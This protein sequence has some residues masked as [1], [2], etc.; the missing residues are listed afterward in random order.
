MLCSSQFAAEWRCEVIETPYA[1]KQA[2]P[3]KVAIS[4]ASIGRTKLYELLND[5]T[6]KSVKI[7]RKRLILR[8]SLD[9]LLT[10]AAA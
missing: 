2:L 3:V 5:G 9:A 6:L 4:A 1:D 7:G 10:P 8:S